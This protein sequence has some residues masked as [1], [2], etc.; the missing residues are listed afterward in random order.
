MQGIYNYVPEIKDVY[1]VYRFAAVLYLQFVLHVML[2]RPWIVIIIII[3]FYFRIK[4]F[5]AI[6]EQKP[7]KF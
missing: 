5:G 7:M 1:R 6:R 3:L 4:N 2:F